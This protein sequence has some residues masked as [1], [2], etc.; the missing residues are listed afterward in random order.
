MRV[1]SKAVW[2]AAL[3]FWLLIPTP[4]AADSGR[5]KPDKVDRYLAEDQS[6]G[7][8]RVIIRTR[9]GATSAVKERIR[10]H[11]DPVY[12]DH[13]SIEALGAKVHADDI[14]ALAA[15]PDI[16]SI[17][18]DARVRATGRRGDARAGSEY[19]GELKASL[20]LE[21]LLTGSTITVAV[22]DSGLAPGEDF[23]GRI[24]G[25][26]D[27]SN[28][29]PGRSAPASDDYGHGTHV[30]GLLGSSG[31]SS[32][33]RYAGVASRVRFLPLKVLD[34]NGAG[35]TSDVIRALEFA[36]ANKARFNIR[37]INL[38][39]GH[40]IYES[41][42]T[43]PLV[44]AVER[45][46]REGIIVVTAAGNYGMNRTTRQVGYAGVASPGNAPSAITVGAAGTQGTVSRTDDR[47]APYSSRG[48][49]WYD[50][51]AKPDVVAPGDSMVSNLA[52]GSTLATTYSSLI[53]R[54][55]SK[56]YLRL[57]GS[58]MATGVV[59]G[60]V[61][62]MLEANDYH[63]LLRTYRGEP[64]GP[65]L[66]ANAVKAMLQYS[67][68]PLRDDGGNPYDVLTQGAG[69]VNGIGAITLAWH[70]DTAKSTGSFWLGDNVEPVTKFSGT[71]EV[72]S[73]TL[74]WGT[75]VVTGSSLIEVN[76]PAW[77]DNIVW[78]TGELDNIA[79]GTT[80]RGD[81]IVWGTLL[82]GLDVAWLGNVSLGDNI[83]WGTVGWADNI[84]WGTG[85]I[86]F[87]NGDNIVWG[88]WDRDNIVWG[89]W[90]RDNIV[91]GTLR[92]DNIV[93]GT[94]DKLLESTG[95]PILGG[96]L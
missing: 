3:A 57:G 64:A 51:I 26:Y 69:L 12:S 29:R 23:D 21:G 47:V 72:W 31:K 30:A 73:Q 1:W 11:G 49:S 8:R 46:V 18:V 36:V 6:T 17:S 65:V 56:R 82:G 28:G 94:V 16:E 48:P 50:G 2:G 35:Y 53:V 42:A 40:P 95:L 38:S 86:G 81:N 10:A 37:V 9:R 15:D 70:A 76:Q 75:R 43:D 85:L 74:I 54:N 33:N 44:Q 32:A 22:L 61:A 60:L 96:G 4:A 25:F 19:V 80:N 93:W 90:G 87:F 62:L 7:P 68:T 88:T 89:T 77:A 92:D 63:R 14:A 84:V 83:V 67:A 5:K 78:G 66:T 71:Y 55:K 13:S 27:F 34:A 20:G 59:S 24:A 45:A 79:W 41:A 58:S 39:L 91:W 52:D